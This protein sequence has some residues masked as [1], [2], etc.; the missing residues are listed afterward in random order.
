VNDQVK[1]YQDSNLSKK[2]Q[3]EQMFDNISHKYDFLN[4]FLS[5]GIDKIWR[6]KTIKVVGENNPKYILD[7]ATGTGDLAFVAQK[8][9]NP[10]KIVGLDLSNGML[11]VGRQKSKKRGLEKIIEFT[12]G[13]SE[14]LPF[15]DNLFDAV[16]V[17]FG[18]RNF[19]NLIA[20]LSEINR[21]LKKDGKITVLEFSKPSTFPVKQAY[22]IY[23]KYL[24]PIFGAAISKDKSAYQYL[25]ESVAAFPEGESF[26]RKLESAGF[27]SFFMKRLSGGIAT[28]YSAKK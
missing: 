23:S 21:V 13:D 18:V 25:P 24:L 14:K 2:K 16:M 28:I 22:G 10:N 20:G 3:V 5:F 19:E 9:L 15:E 11:N 4:H 17:S 12:Q 7:V 6:N 26:L 27:N 8:K 1:P